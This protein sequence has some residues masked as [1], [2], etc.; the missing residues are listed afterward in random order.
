M[1]PL[2][3]YL[4]PPASLTYVASS[5]PLVSPGEALAG[6]AGS[7]RTLSGEEGIRS[8]RIAPLSLVAEG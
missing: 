2:L 1:D 6:E 3:N 4:N 8:S 5:S 7:S